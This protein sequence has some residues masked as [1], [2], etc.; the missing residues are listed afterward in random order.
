MT[1]EFDRLIREDQMDDLIEMTEFI[2]TT[3]KKLS[4]EY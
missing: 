2:M 3:L 1:V 4:Q